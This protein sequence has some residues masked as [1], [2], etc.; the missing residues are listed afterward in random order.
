NDLQAQRDTVRPCVG[1][2]LRALAAVND[3][4]AR[5]KMQL[6][7]VPGERL[8]LNFAAS[9]SRQLS[10]HTRPDFLAERVTRQVRGQS[11]HA[12]EQQQAY[13]GLD[14]LETALFP[15]RI[16]RDHGLAPGPG[17][18]G[19]ISMLSI[20]ACARKA[21]IQS[22]SISSPRCSTRIFSIWSETAASAGSGAP[23]FRSWG[24]NLSW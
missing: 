16:R 22:F 11:H 1:L 4:P 2:F 14:P 7:E 21:L 3:Q 23:R 8:D 20:C 13:R 15:W 18:L 9:H 17:L 10:Y 19:G 6:R 5:F 12:T 24:R